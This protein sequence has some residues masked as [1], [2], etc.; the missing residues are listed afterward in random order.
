MFRRSQTEEDSM[1]N[2]TYLSVLFAIKGHLYSYFISLQKYFEWY[3]VT[4]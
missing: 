2:K 4:P 1:G 3:C